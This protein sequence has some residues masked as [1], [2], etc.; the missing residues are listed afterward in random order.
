MVKSKREKWIGSKIKPFLPLLW[1]FSLQMGFSLFLLFCL[2]QCLSSWMGCVS[3]E[4]ET[5][6]SRGNVRGSYYVRD[7]LPI[8]YQQEQINEINTLDSW[9]MLEIKYQGHLIATQEWYKWLEMTRLVSYDGWHSVTSVNKKRGIL[10][11]AS[12]A[13]GFK[14]NSST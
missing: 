6:Q 11:K 12:K 10:T 8:L 9:E 1:G 4:G 3:Y 14:E 13:E 7:F 2:N 5:I